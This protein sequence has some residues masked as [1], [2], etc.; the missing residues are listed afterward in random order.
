MLANFP[1]K[2]F[3][4]LYYNILSDENY[5]FRALVYLHCDWSVYLRLVF[6]KLVELFWRLF[7]RTH[8]GLD[9]EG[10]QCPSNFGSAYH[11]LVLMRRPR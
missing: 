8:F 3:C 1:E 7:R 9:L 2:G 4:I 5:L 11:I 6:V 10:F